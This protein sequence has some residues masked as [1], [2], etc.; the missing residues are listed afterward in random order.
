MD[1]ATLVTLE[2]LPRQAGSRTREGFRHPSQSRHPFYILFVGYISFGDGGHS[3][4]AVHQK[5]FLL[6]KTPVYPGDPGESL[7]W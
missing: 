5:N 6:S 1:Y 2:T 4:H 7:V 3:A